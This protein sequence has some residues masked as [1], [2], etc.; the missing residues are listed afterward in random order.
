LPQPGGSIASAPSV[1]VRLDFEASRFGAGPA[2]SVPVRTVRGS[3]TLAYA[4]GDFAASRIAS[5]DLRIGGQPFTTADVVMELQRVN[6][7][8]SNRP[9]VLLRVGARPFDLAVGGYSN[10]FLLVVRLDGSEPPLGERPIESFSYAVPS[11][12]EVYETRSG[13]A[14]AT[15]I[16]ATS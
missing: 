2:D 11:D 10:D 9:Q 6:G 14:R 7:P 13:L 5:I 8:P 4:P 12:R 1:T 16:G 3:V 15:L